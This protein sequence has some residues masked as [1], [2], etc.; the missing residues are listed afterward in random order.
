MGMG[1]NP[2]FPNNQ[3]NQKEMENN[4]LMKIENKNCINLIFE[5]NYQMRTITISCNSSDKIDEVFNKLYSKIGYKE[6]EAIFI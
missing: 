3:M 1:M 5:L 4:C 6:G 2:M